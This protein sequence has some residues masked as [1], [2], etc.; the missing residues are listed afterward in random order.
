MEIRYS[1]SHSPHCANEALKG[2]VHDIDC[3]PDGDMVVGAHFERGNS[4]IA[5]LM[6]HAGYEVG[7]YVGGPSGATVALL[8]TSRQESGS[9][10]V[11]IVQQV[12]DTNG[13][14]LDPDRITI[15]IGQGMRAVSQL[16]INSAE[17]RHGIYVVDD[18]E[19]V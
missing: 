19:T 1:Y 18:D 5:M 17:Y 16:L 15:K 3:G 10:Q 2:V 13:E 6:T 8:V 7:P 4:H 12:T 9:N 14:T 11:E